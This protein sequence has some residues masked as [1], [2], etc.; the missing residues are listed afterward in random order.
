MR[1]TLRTGF[2]LWIALLAGFPF[3]Q[4][5]ASAQ[6]SD[7]NP[8]LASEVLT[9]QGS[10]TTVPDSLV[11]VLARIKPHPNDRLFSSEAARVLDSYLQMQNRGR[12]RVP[13]KSGWFDGEA[14][15]YWYDWKDERMTEV[16]FSALPPE[17]ELAHL[18]EWVYEALLYHSNAD[19]ILDHLADTRT[20]LE[21]R[22]LSE[23]SSRVLSD[24][25]LSASVSILLE[26]KGEVIIRAKNRQSR[27][28][29]RK[30][31]GIAT[32]SLAL[33]H[34]GTWGGQQLAEIYYP[35]WE[36]FFAFLKA[37]QLPFTSTTV[38]FLVSYFVTT[39]VD[40]AVIRRKHRRY[41]KN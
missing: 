21:Q 25:Q 17:A 34:L 27:N 39:T 28:Q 38:G 4:P 9:N 15:E 6:H 18:D 7:S 41:F 10:G 16:G 35:K 40:R 37:N 23:S 33:L 3:A 14:Y 24:E 12:V 1:F 31:F 29:T 5:Q 2:G 22:G 30:L 13:L 32:C 19:A 11:K 36:P 26:K 20:Y 8:Y